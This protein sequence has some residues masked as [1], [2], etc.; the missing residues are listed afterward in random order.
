MILPVLNQQL[1]FVILRMFLW[2]CFTISYPDAG[3]KKKTTQQHDF[4]HNSSTSADLVIWW[5]IDNDI[6]VDI[7]KTRFSKIFDK[8]DHGLLLSRF[9]KSDLSFSLIILSQSYLYNRKQ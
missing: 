7:I 6:Q 2:C 8:M 5:S 1:L 9:I 3:N 4:V